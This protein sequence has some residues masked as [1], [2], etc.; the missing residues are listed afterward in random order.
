MP[1]SMVVGASL[2]LMPLVRSKIM[3][4]YHPLM[5]NSVVG[6]SS[7]GSNMIAMYQDE[8]RPSGLSSARQYALDQTMMQQKGTDVRL[9][10]IL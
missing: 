3:P 5:I 8:H 2:L 1:A 9:R 10:H 6:Y 7:G 4:P